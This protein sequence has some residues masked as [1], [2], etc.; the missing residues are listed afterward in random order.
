VLKTMV[1]TAPH[2]C[3]SYNRLT[4]VVVSSD[5]PSMAFDISVHLVGLSGRPCRNGSEGELGCS[6]DPAPVV[7]GLV[8]LSGR[9]CGS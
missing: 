7:G 1:S 5:T 9:S 6:A 2:T 3:I 4:P 8:G